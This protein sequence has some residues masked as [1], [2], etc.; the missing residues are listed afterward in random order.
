MTCLGFFLAPRLL[1]WVIFGGYGR[2][3][4][5]YWEAAVAVAVLA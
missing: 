2:I 5:I 4:Y 1:S 3:S